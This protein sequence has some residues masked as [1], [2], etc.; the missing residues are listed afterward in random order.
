MLFLVKVA[1]AMDYANKIDAAGGPG[2]T[3]AKIVERFRPQAF[4][5]N[6]TRREGI[7]IVELETAAKVAEL[8][9]VLTWFTGGEP[10]FTPLIGPEL[11]DEAIKN[12]KRI[13]KPPK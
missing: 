13:V 1:A 11:F 8:M 7:M 10:S 2:S 4:Y 3:F 5:G 12:A 9:Y 6:P